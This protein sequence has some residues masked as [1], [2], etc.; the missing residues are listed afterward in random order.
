MAW[1]TVRRAWWLPPTQLVCPWLPIG[2]T[3]PDAL[4]TVCCAA[5]LAAGALWGGKQRAHDYHWVAPTAARTHPSRLTHPRYKSKNF[6]F[7]NWEKTAASDLIGC[8][9]GAH[10]QHS[11]LLA[12]GWQQLP[13]HK[14]SMLRIETLM[15]TF[16]RP[17]R[18]SRRTRVTKNLVN[19]LL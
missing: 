9:Q 18:R 10:A 2:N 4:V 16:M 8:Q 12:G 11:P 19:L 1:W 5:C 13:S 6:L 15:A 3:S 14:S 7:P 17:I